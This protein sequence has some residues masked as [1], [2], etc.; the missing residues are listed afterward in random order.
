MALAQH[1]R[2]V[3]HPDGGAAHT[4]TRF[5][6]LRVRAGEDDIEAGFERRRRGEFLRAL[7]EIRGRRQRG[8]PGQ[9]RLARQHCGELVVVKVA[10][11]PFRL[12]HVRREIDRHGAEIDM[13]EILVGHIERGQRRGPH[14]L[15]GEGNGRRLDLL[16]Q[17]VALGA[18]DGFRER[19]E[20]AL[21]QLARLGGLA[22]LVA[23]VGKQVQRS[24][25]NLVADGGFDETPE[26]RLVADVLVVAHGDVEGVVE[27]REVGVEE[28]RVVGVVLVETHQPT[29]EIER[30]DDRRIGKRLRGEG[31]VPAEESRGI[32]Q[33]RAGGGQFKRVFRRHRALLAGLVERQRLVG[34]EVEERGAVGVGH[35]ALLDQVVPL[36]DG[37]GLERGGV[38][39]RGIEMF[40]DLGEDAREVPRLDVGARRGGGL[41]ALVEAP[42]VVL[43]ILPIP[44]GEQR[45]HDGLHRGGS[46]GQLGFEACDFLL[47]LVALDQAFE[48]DFATDGAHGLGVG[49]VGKRARD[50][51]VEPLDGGLRQALC[52]GL[53]D[54]FP[55]GIARAGKGR[56]NHGKNGK[57]RSKEACFHGAGGEASPEKT[58]NARAGD[59]G[60][61]AAH[62]TRA[63]GKCQAFG[64]K[65]ACEGNSPAGPRW[66]KKRPDSAVGALYERG[67]LAVW[68]SA[69]SLR[70][71]ATGSRGRR[72][73]P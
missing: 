58:R 35:V 54:G 73:R 56:R 57:S 11:I 51:R 48:G 62:A 45:L 25:G 34:E 49:L 44:V 21:R 2:E 13:L 16:D 5:R 63:P 72:G 36:R 33:R 10:N 64:R 12:L 24:G 65:T 32:I 39:Q 59:I 3:A 8:V 47:G 6:E 28:G 17:V 69:V 15:G 38:G 18:S 42:P 43:E 1:Q 67:C 37:R 26:R 53:V 71:T 50:D 55:L 46:L 30:P 19:S 40:P 41:R 9:R 61:T 31:G 66:T 27:P 7:L 20:A 68:L 52:G 22:G 14:L 29:V 60:G 23:A 4:I 70:H